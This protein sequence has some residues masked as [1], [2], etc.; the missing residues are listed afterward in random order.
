MDQPL[1]VAFTKFADMLPWTVW[2]GDWC[3]P[4]RHWRGKDLPFLT[5]ANG[6]VFQQRVL[7]EMGVLLLWRTCYSHGHLISNSTLL[8]TYSKL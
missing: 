3:R 2:K 8:P 6:A 7:D 4:M 5:E 1:A